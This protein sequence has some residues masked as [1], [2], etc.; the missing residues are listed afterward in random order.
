MPLVTMK[1][2]LDRA[3]YEKYAVGAF[4]FWSLDSAQAVVETEAELELP[5]I[6]QCGNIEATQNQAGFK[7]SVP[8]LFGS[9]KQAGKELAKSKMKL[10]GMI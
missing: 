9:S 5:V 6:L 2:I 1:S 10:F 8:T 3:R 4:E 7:Y